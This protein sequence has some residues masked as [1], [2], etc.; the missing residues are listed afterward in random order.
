M[1][2]YRGRRISPARRI[3]TVLLA[4]IAAG[5]LC[6]AS[7]LGVVLAGDRDDLTGYDPAVVV[8]LG[9]QVMPS[10]EPS[11][12]LRDRLDTALT[13]LTDWPDA[14]IVVSGGQG[15]NEPSSEAQC[16]ADYLAAH[17]VARERI[18]LEDASRNTD[19]NLRNT[20]ALLAEAG[21]DPTG[22]IAVV[23]N[24][25]HLARVR[26]LWGRVGGG[27]DNL[28]TVAAPS[29]HAPSRLMMYLREPLALVKSFLFDRG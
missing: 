24:G 27:Q 1:S 5:V 26:M 10:G 17:G 29:S 11:I 18:L 3:L 14:I 25:F 6:F 28:S 22:E 16:M 7:L 20:V 19:Q 21:Y 4:L 8:V 15:V 23:S 9:C 13:C 12:L 2:A